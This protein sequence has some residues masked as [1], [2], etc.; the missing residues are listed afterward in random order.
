M[1]TKGFYSRRMIECLATS[2][3]ALK[4]GGIDQTEG[5]RL[6]MKGRSPEAEKDMTT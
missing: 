4:G 1:D 5:V 2:P 3:S 6:R